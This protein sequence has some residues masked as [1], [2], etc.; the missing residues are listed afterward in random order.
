MGSF[1]VNM[2][3]R[4]RRKEKYLTNSLASQPIQTV[5][6]IRSWTSELRKKEASR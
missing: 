2:K 5:Q 6:R 4:F 3:N 1:D